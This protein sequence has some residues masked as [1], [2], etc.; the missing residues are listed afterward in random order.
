MKEIN[1]GDLDFLAD[2]IPDATLADIENR[3]QQ[4]IKEEKPTEQ[5][6]ASSFVG[7]KLTHN[8]GAAMTNHAM[9]EES[10]NLVSEK[11]LSRIG[12]SISQNADIRDGWM[13]VDKRLLGDRANFYPEDWNFRIRPANVEAIRNWSTIDDENPNSIDDVFNEILKS[14]LSIVTPRGPL[15]WSNVRSWDRF[16]FILLIRE[17]TFVNG[18]KKLQFEEDCPNCD[19]SVPFA[20]TSVSLDYDLPDPEIYKYFNPETQTWLIDPTEYDVDADPITLYLPTLE[21][22]AA[23]KSWLIQRVQDKKKVDNVFMKF[24]PWLAPKIS[25]DDK[26]ASRQIREYEMIFKSWDTDMFSF[27]DEVISNI[28]I[29]PATRLISSCPVCGEEVTAEIRFPDGVRSIFAISNRRKKF[30]NK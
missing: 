27:M 10:K 16:F 26:V 21:K 2:Q 30:G 19:N 8:I 20:L 24:L 13:E 25:K 17:Y 15:P 11:K 6:T 23:I 5:P 4:E 28:T 3:K 12:D 1:E 14:C 29:I 18:E 22:D 7:Q 9:G